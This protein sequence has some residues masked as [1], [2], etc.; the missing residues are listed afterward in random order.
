MKKRTRVAKGLIA[1]AVPFL[2]AAVLYSSD[3]WRPARLLIE[4]EG[5]RGGAPSRADTELMCHQAVI[6]PIPQLRAG[7]SCGGSYAALEPILGAAAARTL[8][9]ACHDKHAV[10]RDGSVGLPNTTLCGEVKQACNAAC[11]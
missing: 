10:I 11:E 5:L 8:V 6:K 1:L 3:G 2:F 4:R 9:Q 7:G